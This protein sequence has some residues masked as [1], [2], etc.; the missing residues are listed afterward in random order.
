M[1]SIRRQL[2]PWLKVLAS[3]GV[4]LALVVWL[5]EFIPV[6][7][8]L[9]LVTQGLVAAL[10]GRVLGLSPF[11]I[12]IQILLPLAAAYNA[13]VPAWAYLAAFVVCAL[14]Y[15]NS[16]SE[17]V[18]LYLTNRKTWQALDAIVSEQK[19]RSFVDLGSGM[20]GVVTFLAGANPALRARGVETAPLVF[21]AS[22]VRLML[23][24]LPNAEFA[25]CSIWDE[26]LSAHDVVYCF[27]SPVPMPKMFAK[28][29][30]EMR[31]GTLFVSNSF[32]VP[33]EEPEAVV[34]VDDTRKTRLYLYR[35]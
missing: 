31:R 25:Y 26:D 24:R 6:G 21:V 12:P 27:L 29:K 2:F 33:G 11:W 20:G 32:T 18:P 16:A 19:A 17:Q 28:A 7:G 9:L 5:R 1:N 3:Q 22:R 34:E 8:P 23:R 13:V 15:W 4:V 30:A 10:I 35:I 14:I